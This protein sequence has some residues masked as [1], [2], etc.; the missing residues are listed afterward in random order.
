MA[1]LVLYASLYPFSGWRWPAGAHALALLELPWPPWQAPFD[2]LFNTLGYLPLG[3]LVFVAAVRAGRGTVAALA[4]AVVAPSALAY[5]CEVT[6]HLLPGRH[7]STKDWLTN[8][9]GAVA[10]ALLGLVLHRLGRLQ[11]LHRWR[12]RWITRHS[13]GAVALLALWPLGLLFPT[14]VPWAQG[15]IGPYLSELAAGAL[16]DVSWAAAVLGWLYARP[17]AQPL[18]HLGERLLSMLGLL[19]PV[20]LA[21]AVVRPGLPRLVAAAGAIALG[22][23]AMAVSTL[24]N[25]GPAHAWAWVTAAALVGTLAAALVSLALVPLPQR[26][27]QGLALVA[28]TLQVT[29]VAQAPT[30]P[31]FA[32]NLQSWEQ[33]RF[34]HFHGLAQ[35][36][37]LLWP[38][39]AMVWLLA[40][41]A[42]RGGQT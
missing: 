25:F 9:L 3:L 6:Q 27:V 14:P 13:A 38:Y 17:D 4:W 15:Q 2:A 18:S 31:Y 10:G 39:V 7:P 32:Q 34:V 20:M 24:L 19:A 21:Y 36:V 16:A 41:S 22:V 42:R 30:D 35:W 37:G 11:Q 1:A 28:L 8:T 40:R 5:G 12:Q 33:G 26:V 29:L 23:A